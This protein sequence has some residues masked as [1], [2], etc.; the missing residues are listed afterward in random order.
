MPLLSLI[1]PRVSKLYFSDMSQ[2]RLVSD[3]TQLR[4]SA[5][6][7]QIRSEINRRFNPLAGG[8][9]WER[10]RGL[11]EHI[12]ETEGVDLLVAI[13]YA[14]SAV[15]TQGLAGLANGLELQAA[16]N[17]KFAQ[18]SVLPAA[19][20][21]ELYTWMIGR[22]APEIRAL[23]PS[24]NQLRDLYRCE[25]A[26]Q[27]LH[28]MLSKS[29]PDHVPD[30]E[31]IGFIIFEHI[32]QLEIEARSCQL[33]AKE[34]VDNVQKSNKK[35]RVI[36]FFVGAALG[37]MAIIPFSQLG[38]GASTPT[39]ALTTEQRVPKILSFD[40]GKALKS[41]F[42][43]NTVE[44]YKTDLVSL[45]TNTAQS[46]VDKD[47]GQ[48]FTQALALSESIQRLY[49]HDPNVSISREKLARWQQGTLQEI[50]KQ[51]RRFAAARTRAANI[52]RLSQ[53]GD[54][55][56][57]RALSKDLEQ[58]AISLSPLYGRAIYIEELMKDGSL[59]QAQSELNTLMNSLKGLS[60]KSSQLEQ[61][62]KLLLQHPE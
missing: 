35:F 26:C 55:V 54:I 60:F 18:S 62:L 61:S 29:Q 48:D 30:L 2:F 51:Y 49:P 34:N 13:Y 33:S 12:G 41:K 4:E 21:A 5:T 10:V 36:S 11:C 39:L 37:T 22:V 59:E 24:I 58:Y 25:R 47:I 40:E 38:I 27:S 50:D 19:R 15:K 53:K 14:V 17:S 44:A 56:A 45:Y 8:I 43:S 32:D 7:Q 3:E 16:V 1:G 57:V 42:G 28:D 20:R 46:L 23:R 9:N 6:Y 31:S 52:H